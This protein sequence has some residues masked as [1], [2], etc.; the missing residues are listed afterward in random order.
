MLTEARYNKKT[1]L[2]NPMLNSCTV[3]ATND[4][5]VTP[6]GPAAS[7]PSKCKSWPKHL[8]VSTEKGTKPWPCGSTLAHV[9]CFCWSCCAAAAPAVTAARGRAIRDRGWMMN[10]LAME[11]PWGR[12]RRMITRASTDMAEPSADVLVPSVRLGSRQRAG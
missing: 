2:H 6:S 10:T 8:H 1:L 4:A 3:P 5:Y 11:M 12:T 7:S 9:V